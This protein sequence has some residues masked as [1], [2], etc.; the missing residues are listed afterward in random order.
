M[1]KTKKQIMKHYNGENLNAADFSGADLRGVNFEGAV[2]TNANFSNCRTGLKTSSSVILF[3][4]SLAVSLLSGYMAMLSIATIRD[5]VETSNSTL[6]ISGYVTLGLMIAFLLIMLLKGGKIT[7]I[8]IVII[9]PLILITGLIAYL[10]GTGTGEASVQSS[11]AL[12]FFTVMVIVG[13]IARASAGTLSSNIIFIAV[14]MS[15]PLFGKFALGAGIGTTVLAVACAVIS[16]QA[17]SG[18]D[19]FI[20]LRNAAL[21]AGTFFGTSFVNA[22]LTGA[23]FSGAVI[24]NTNFTGATLSA[25]NWENSKREYNIEDAQDTLK[26]NKE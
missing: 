4:V 18:S 22:D 19:K 15:G 9:I 8:S 1:E 21:K 24:K 10:T 13:I 6:V 16:K 25:V 14:A 12:V 7:L 11:L 26:Q 3:V 17:L 20:W 2:L 5:M 23:D